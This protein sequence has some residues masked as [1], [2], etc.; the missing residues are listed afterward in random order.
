M[1]GGPDP[2]SHPGVG[3]LRFPFCSPETSKLTSLPGGKAP[4][5]PTELY[6]AGRLREAIDAQVAEVKAKPADQARRLFLFELLAF[7]GEL[8]RATRQIDAI[9]YDD[10]DLALASVAYRKLIDAET[11]RRKCF[12]GVEPPEILGPLTESIRLRLEA[13]A[14]IRSGLPGDALTRLDQANE[15]IPAVAGTLNGGRFSTLRDADDLFG[16]VL[17]VLAQGKYFWV[18]LGQ[19][20]ALAMKPPRFPRDLLYVPARL[21]LETESGEVFLPTLYPRSHAHAVDAIRLGRATDWET[22]DGGPTLGVG[23]RLFLVDDD[24][25]GLLEWREL[26]RDEPTEE[27]AR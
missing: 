7:A 6:Q 25:V 11:A 9:K 27:L 14:A 3:T 5:T 1:M 8:D 15:A 12:E 18:D 10:P 22:L 26:L 4:V 2:W 24:A 17:E 16:G 13:L 19:V 23:A 20:V 21:D